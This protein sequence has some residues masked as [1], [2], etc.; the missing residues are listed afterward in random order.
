[1]TP[2]E[3]ILESASDCFTYDIDVYV[4]TER[5]SFHELH[6]F[7]LMKDNEIMIYASPFAMRYL[8]DELADSLKNIP[9][10]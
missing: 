7:R 2:K 6:I 10:D 3:F 4:K 9:T 8:W 1:M 5:N